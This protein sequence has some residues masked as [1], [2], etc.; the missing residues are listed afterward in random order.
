MGNAGNTW[1]IKVRGKVKSGKLKIKELFEHDADWSCGF[2]VLVYEFPST[3][4][5]LLISLS[6]VVLRLPGSA[7][8]CM[9]PHAVGLP[10]AQV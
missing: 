2:E 6:P 7:G 10:T 8:M 1:D 3:R 9:Q 5:C 4:R